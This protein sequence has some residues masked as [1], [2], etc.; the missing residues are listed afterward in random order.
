MSGYLALSKPRLTAL[1]VLSGMAGEA[2]ARD[3]LE[4]NMASLQLA[5]GLFALG[6]G[7]NT[8]NQLMERQFDALMDRTKGRPLPEGRVSPRQ[9]AVFACVSCAVGLA[10]LASRNMLA[11]ELGVATLLSYTLLYTPLKRITSLCTLAG[12]LPGALPPLVGFASIAGYLSDEAWALS[13]IL[14]LWQMP[15][16]FAI[17]WIYR[18]DY[19]RGGF[20]MISVID[21]DKGSMTVRQNLV[22]TFAL[23]S[24]S[25]LP[26]V[27]GHAGLIYFL[28]AIALGVLFVT[29]SLSI[30]IT[31]LT[32]VA[33][34]RI[35]VFSI[36][37]LTLLLG[38][39]V[40][41]P[42]R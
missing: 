4:F 40:M 15:H 19:A 20:P 30:F 7:S 12:A 37:Y 8:V 22:Y 17:S 13:L 28:G 24:A 31:G 10:I 25:L 42:V 35:F 14:F 36:I 23:L 11:L 38:I 16:F 6:A 3:S 5:L 27:L 33:A 21:D 32:P 18:N 29:L 41:D 2:I 1:S 9:A 26:S 39:L 34:R